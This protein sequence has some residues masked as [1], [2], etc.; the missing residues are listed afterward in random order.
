MAITA[1][2]RYFQGQGKV[3]IAVRN[4]DGTNQGFIHLGNC[5]KLTES[6]KTEEQV[7]YE[8]MSGQQLETKR[9][10][11]KKTCEVSL[12]ID[13]QSPENMAIALYGLITK[14][15]AGS[16]TDKAY[17][18]H[19][20][21]HIPLDHMGITTVVVKNYSDTTTYAAGTDYIVNAAHGS[22]YIPSTSTILEDEVLNIAYSFAAQ[23]SL[24]ALATA[25]VEFALR[26]EGLNIA[27]SNKE[28]VVNIH[29]FYPAPAKDYGQI[30]DKVQPIE[31]SGGAMADTT[32]PEKDQFMTVITLD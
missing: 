16:V 3:F 24:S 5:T 27:E 31:L 28:V 32:R 17:T 2:D 1:N 10:P 9:V 30:S 8:S 4:T 19:K 20:D 18:A 21:K 11:G 14:K 15:A 25:G 12:T 7:L 23:S 26:F 13:N 29:K 6:L 22:I